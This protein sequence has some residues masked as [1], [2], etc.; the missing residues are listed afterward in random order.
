M[1]EELHNEIMKEASLDAPF[2]TLLD[3]AVKWAEY[4]LRHNDSET[5]EEGLNISKALA[6]YHYATTF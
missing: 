3:T 1:M 6:N 5:L 4:V 2:K